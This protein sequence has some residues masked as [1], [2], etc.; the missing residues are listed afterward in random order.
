[1]KK[2]IYEGKVSHSRLTPKVHQF[3]YN[4]SYYFFD[5]NNP[6]SLIQ[7]PL[8]LTF[9]IKNYLTPQQIL[10][11]VHETFGENAL[12]L[13][14]N[15]F[16]LTQLSYFG[17]CFNPVSFYYCYD[18]ND[19]LRFIISQITNTPWGEKHI[20]CFDFQKSNGQF[21]FS[22]DFHVSPFMPMEINYSWKFNDPEKTI[23]IL[24]V[25][26]LKERTDSFFFARMDLKAKDLNY[27]NI[28][29]NLVHF[30][31]MSFKTVIG[32]YWQALILYLKRVP[33]YGH[34]KRRE[35]L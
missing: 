2:A 34:P 9:N 7:I 20:N 31:C 26:H 33:F 30:P 3:N 28:L 19:K 24:M 4:V 25:N 13:V 35:V 18:S 27:K 6:K 15:I 12:D 17:F 10:H 1:M 16:V 32:I 5:L 11:R 29:S 23:D 22:K 21:N 14:K 8:L